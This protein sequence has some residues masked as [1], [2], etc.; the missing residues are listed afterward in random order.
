[1]IK[2]LKLMVSV[3][4]GVFSISLSVEISNTLKF[5]SLFFVFDSSVNLF[6]LF[7]FE[8]TLLFQLIDFC[9]FFVNVPDSLCDSSKE[10]FIL[11][12]YDLLFFS[13]WLVLRFLRF[14]GHLIKKILIKKYL[15]FKFQ[16]F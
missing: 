8:I 11:L 9:E 7:R 2:L 13:D 10:R 1:M 16:I 4:L 5:A 15:I 14:F 3:L 12:V 6:D